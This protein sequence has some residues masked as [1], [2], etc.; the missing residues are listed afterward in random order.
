MLNEKWPV[1]GNRYVLESFADNTNSHTTF[2]CF[3]KQ[4]VSEF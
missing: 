3:V 4:N 2:Y 1:D